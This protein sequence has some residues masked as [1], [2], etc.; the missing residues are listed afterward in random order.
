MEAEAFFVCVICLLKRLVG[1][2]LER[3]LSDRHWKPAIVNH[4]ANDFPIPCTLGR[5]K[6][7]DMRAKGQ[8]SHSLE[9][10]V[11]RMTMAPLRP[12]EHCLALGQS[13]SWCGLPHLHLFFEACRKVLVSH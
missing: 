3:K 6:E 8:R 10:S 1:L 11:F 2:S 9:L 13:S 12:Y 7:Q 4:L 5:R